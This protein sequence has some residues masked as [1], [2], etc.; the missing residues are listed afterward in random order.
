[1]KKASEANEDMTAAHTRDR[2][3]H[4]SWFKKRVPPSDESIY[5]STI[6]IEMNEMTSEYIYI[7]MLHS[8]LHS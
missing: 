3:G 5:S 8:M 2:V 6:T 1:M 4:R 7:Y